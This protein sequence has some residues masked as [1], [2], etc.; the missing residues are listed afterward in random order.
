MIMNLNELLTKQNVITKLMLK[1]DDKELS[2]GLKVKIM[3]IRLAYNKV[4]KAFD[5]DVKEF[6]DQIATDEYKKLAGMQERNEEQTNRYN[7]LSEKINSEYVEFITQKGFE[8]VKETIDDAFTEEEFEEILDVNS[9]NNVS[10][11]GN[12]IK[13]ADLIE[14]FYEIFVK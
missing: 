6:V 4:K 2:K 10:I 8:E 9:G 14:A 11:N 3:R 5:D 13:A 7:E 12:D 1:D